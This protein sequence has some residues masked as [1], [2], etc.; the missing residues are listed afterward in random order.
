[1][2]EDSRM[3][4]YWTSEG[5]L[6]PRAMVVMKEKCR[7]IMQSGQLTQAEVS[8]ISKISFL[9]IPPRSTII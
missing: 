5:I 1:M 2:I 9:A 3:T 6:L 4:I 8:K 7:N